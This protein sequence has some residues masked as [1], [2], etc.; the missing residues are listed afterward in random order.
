MSFIEQFGKEVTASSVDTEDDFILR[1]EGTEEL[2]TAKWISENRPALDESLLVQG[3]IFLTGFGITHADFPHIASEMSLKEKSL[4]YIRGTSPRP[5]VSPLRLVTGVGTQITTERRR[6]GPR[7]RFGFFRPIP[8]TDLR[9][10]EHI[11]GQLLIIT[12]AR[13]P[14]DVAREL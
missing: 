4:E 11:P 7:A 14:G 5:K 1:I 13:R 10:H 12:G 3:S 9:G 6:F 8:G 2:D